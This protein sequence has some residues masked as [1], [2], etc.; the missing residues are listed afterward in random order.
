M[1][2][3]Y[4]L[5]I[6]YSNQLCS[7]DDYINKQKVKIHN[8]AMKN[9]IQIQRE[10]TNDIKNGAVVLIK[11]LEHDNEK[12]RLNAAAQCLQIGIQQ[13][14]AIEVLKKIENNSTDKLCQLDARMILKGIY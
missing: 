14:K 13:E 9:L 1:K 8:K 12:V 5:F 7:K 3:Y 4:N 10:I 2:N 11:L 6:K